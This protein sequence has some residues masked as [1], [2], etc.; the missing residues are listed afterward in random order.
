M[1]LKPVF[2]SSLAFLDSRS[3]ALGVRSAQD[4][5]TLIQKSTRW[6]FSR[7]RGI[8]SQ[9]IG[10][11]HTEYSSYTTTEVQYLTCNVCANVFWGTGTRLNIK[12]AFSRCGIHML[13]IIRSWDRLNLSMGIPIL[14]DGTFILRRATGSHVPDLVSSAKWTGL[15]MKHIFKIIRPLTLNKYPRRNDTAIYAWLISKLP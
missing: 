7:S 15:H 8:Y 5:D 14:V 10:I 11:F 1:Y 9:V 3:P 12:T 13:K 6:L 2:L 4:R